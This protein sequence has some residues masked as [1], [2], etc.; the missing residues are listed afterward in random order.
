[1]ELCYLV[2]TFLCHECKF[3]VLVLPSLANTTSSVKKM[4]GT[5]CSHGCRNSQI[6][7]KQVWSLSKRCCTLWRWYRQILPWCKILHTCVYAT[8]V[9]LEILCI[10]TWALL[11]R[12]QN[13]TFSTPLLFTF[14]ICSWEGISLVQNSV[15]GFECSV[16]CLMLLVFCNSNP[17]ISIAE[18]IYKMHVS[19]FLICKSVGHFNY[20]NL[21][22]HSH[23]AIANSPDSAQ[24]GIWSSYS[25]A[26]VTH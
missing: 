20:L 13:V 19:I 23:A 14:C 9:V 4:S 18:T 17:T 12:C 21:L 15:Y 16:L 11:H 5:I 7:K 22:R 1:M 24:A 6:L 2:W 26:I 25:N 3:L 10:H 8:S